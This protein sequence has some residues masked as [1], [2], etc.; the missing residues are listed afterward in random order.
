M[1]NICGKHFKNECHSF[2]RRFLES[3]VCPPLCQWYL[4]IVFSPTQLIIAITGFIYTVPAAAKFPFTQ[5]SIALLL[6][7]NQASAFNFALKAPG[8]RLPVIS[9]CPNLVGTFQFSSTLQRT[10]FDQLKLN[11]AH[12][13]ALDLVSPCYTHC[14][15]YVVL[16]P[17][18]EH[19]Q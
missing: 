11:Q 18:K 13:R 9:Q 6:T 7:A 3:G 19:H 12:C 8:R 1:N 5:S 15:M 2:I 10:L 4:S 17:R 16:S 14:N